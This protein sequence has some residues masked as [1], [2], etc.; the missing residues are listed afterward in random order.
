MQAVFWVAIIPA[1]VAVA[2]VVLGVEG[3]T[4]P[5]DDAKARP[6]IQFRDMANIGRAFWIIVMIGFMF[7][8]ARFS[9]AFL[10]LKA[11]AEGLP[12]ALT[13]LVFVV[14]NAVYALGAYPA[15]AMWRLQPDRPFIGANLMVT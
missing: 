6:R 15:S 9:E 14:M 1:A 8:L 13:P 12:L 7:T 4:P 10:V 3:R 2:C 5:A 11:N